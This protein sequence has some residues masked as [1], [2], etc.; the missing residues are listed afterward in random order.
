MIPSEFREEPGSGL[1]VND[2]SWEELK[3]C[4]SPALPVT[5]IWRGQ[6]GPQGLSTVSYPRVLFQE[7]EAASLVGG[8]CHAADV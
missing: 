2:L 6:G 5:P 1:Y 4:T 8:L 3:H 7:Y